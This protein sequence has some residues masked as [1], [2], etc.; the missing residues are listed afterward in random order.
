MLNKPKFNF[1]P[2]ENN[3]NKENKKKNN[4]I[5]NTKTSRS[6]IT[7]SN[8]IV[9]ITGFEPKKHLLRNAKHLIL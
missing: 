2:R 5:A 8:S 3:N 1:D 7:L 6:K 9:N 4:N